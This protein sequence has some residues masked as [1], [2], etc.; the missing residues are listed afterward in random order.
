MKRAHHLGRH[1]PVQGAAAAA[2]LHPCHC[3][4]LQVDAGFTAVVADATGI[5]SAGRF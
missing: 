1:A 3:A 4:F 5:S 2:Y